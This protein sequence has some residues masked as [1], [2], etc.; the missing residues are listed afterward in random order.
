MNVRANHKNKPRQCSIPEEYLAE[1]ADEMT[2]RY[3]SYGEIIDF[4]KQRTNE[5]HE[6]EG[7]LGILES[8]MYLIAQEKQHT[9]YGYKTFYC[10]MTK[11]KYEKIAEEHL[12]NA[13]RRLLETISD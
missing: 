1:L 7:I 10:I 2:R 5:R 11:E 3:M 6:L 4:I 9:P 8:R 12:E 13:K